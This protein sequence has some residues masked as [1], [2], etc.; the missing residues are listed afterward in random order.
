ML[1]QLTIGLSSGSDIKGLMT[2]VTKSLSL[3]SSSKGNARA[4]LI[5]VIKKL[6]ASTR[7]NYPN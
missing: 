6:I 7:V 4:R 3:F 2:A 5:A 1:I